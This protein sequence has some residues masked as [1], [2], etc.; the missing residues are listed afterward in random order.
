F[1]GH[2][3]QQPDQDP[4]DPDDP[5]P[6]GLDEILLPD[7]ASSWDGR[8]GKLANVIVDD[9]L[10]AWLRPIAERKAQVCL[11]VDAC[12]SGTVVR[13]VAS[14][15]NRK[16]DPDRLGIPAER[17]DRARQRGSPIGGEG[18][19]PGRARE[20][21]PFGVADTV[22]DLVAISAALPSEPTPELPPPDGST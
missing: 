8:A 12:H 21:T 9:E 4:P 5:E 10:G 1:S 11:I 16:V 14:E 20:E 2:G 22:P 6:D 13:G 7:D 17:L 15:V 19:S 3:S 18:G